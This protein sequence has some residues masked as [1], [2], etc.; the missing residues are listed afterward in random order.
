MIVSKQTK[1]L[2]FTRDSKAL[3]PFLLTELNSVGK[4]QQTG[5][6]RISLSISKALL[7]HFF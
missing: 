3:N 1:E 2:L 4:M 7:S 5:K 6:K